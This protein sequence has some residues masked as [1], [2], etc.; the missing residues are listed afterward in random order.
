MNYQELKTAAAQPGFTAVEMS[1]LKVSVSIEN[2]AREDDVDENASERKQESRAGGRNGF[3]EKNKRYLVN[4]KKGEKI[5]FADAWK[6][7]E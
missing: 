6:G 3:G 2:A 5:T 1:D 4:G 7:F